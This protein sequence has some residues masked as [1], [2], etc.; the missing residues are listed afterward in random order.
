MLVA[1][2]ILIG[3]VSFIVKMCL[4]DGNDKSSKNKKSVM[5]L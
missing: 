2:I 4:K 5:N 3:L 1:L